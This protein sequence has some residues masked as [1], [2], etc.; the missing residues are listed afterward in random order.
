MHRWLLILLLLGGCHSKAKISAPP[1]AAQ[2]PLYLQW[3]A[4]PI[5]ATVQYSCET[6]RNGSDAP[7][8]DVET[9]KKLIEVKPDKVILETGGSMLAGDSRV[10]YPPDRE[11]I[12]AKPPAPGSPEAGTIVAQGDQTLKLAGREWKC[13][14]TERQNGP[15]TTRRWTS[16]EVPGGLIKEFQR[17]EGADLT[18]TQTELMWVSWPKQ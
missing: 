10:E 2:N 13:H 16:E 6:R 14:W 18:E 4:L 1:P 9:W 5:G 7:A 12:L 8:S 11:E 3:A 17:I 15:M